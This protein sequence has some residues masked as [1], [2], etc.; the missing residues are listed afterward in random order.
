VTDSGLFSGR[1]L[2]VAFEGWNDAG[3]A[4]SGAARILIQAMN[5]QAISAIDSQNYFDFQFARPQAFL[6]PAGKREFKWPTASVYRPELPDLFDVRI[7]LGVEPS[8]NWIDFSKEIADVVD[9]EEVD[10]VVFLGAML[11]DAPHTRPIAIT[12]TTTNATVAEETSAEMSMYEGPVG[13]LS[14]LAAEFEARGL[15]TMFLWAA[16]PHYVHNGPVPKATLAMITELETYLNLEFDHGDLANEVFK[17][18]RAVDEMTEGDDDLAEY[19]AALE[20]SRDEIDGATGETIA[21][22]VEKFLRDADEDR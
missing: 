18:D 22:E 14:I 8:R 19:V 12:S 13:I 5:A 7:L 4:S 11:S 15:P 9:G 10:S 16:V 21:R 6:N 17:W 3:E 1:T 2:I 20:K